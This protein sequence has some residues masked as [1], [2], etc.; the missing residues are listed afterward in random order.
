M[1]EIERITFAAVLRSDNCI[2]FGRDHSECLGRTPVKFASGAKQGFL[3]SCMRFVD[4]QEA[5]IL[6]MKANQVVTT[7]HGSGLISEMIWSDSG[8]YEYDLIRGYVRKIE[9][10]LDTETQRR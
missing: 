4:R 8:L 10:N 7:V 5:L 1:K 3:T 2:V 6:A 9:N